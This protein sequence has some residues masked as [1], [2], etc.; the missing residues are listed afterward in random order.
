MPFDAHADRNVGD[1]GKKLSQQ[2]RGGTGS[3]PLRPPEASCLLLTDITHSHYTHITHITLITNHILT[4]HTLHT[5]HPG[6]VAVPEGLVTT[7][8]AALCNVTGHI[9]GDMGCSKLY[10]SHTSKTLLPGKKWLPVTTQKRHS[11][12]LIFPLQK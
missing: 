12:R 8:R 2:E 1:R 5:R 3:R 7:L 6:A 11:M 4:S 10:G 9:V